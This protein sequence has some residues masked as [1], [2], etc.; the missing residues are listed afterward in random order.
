[1]NSSHSVASSFSDNG[2][3][4]CKKF[5]NAKERGIYAASM[6]IA[7]RRPPVA[8]GAELRAA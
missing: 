7:L 4:A 6:R 1:M 2:G 8:G 3:L 5:P